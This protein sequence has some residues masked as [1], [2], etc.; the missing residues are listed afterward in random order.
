[1]SAFDTLSPAI[2]GNPGT[3]PRIMSATTDNTLAE[4]TTAGYVA[5][6]VAKKILKTFDILFINYDMDG[7]PGHGVFTVTATSSGSLVSYQQ[8]ASNILANQ[9]SWAG[10]SAS[11][12]FTITG[13]TTSSIVIPAIE[14]QANT[15]YIV[16]YVITANTL[17]ITFSADPGAMVLDYVAF[18]AAQ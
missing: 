18:I 5:D 15:S 9:A 2:Q 10:G 4:I 8:A 17:T 14:T 1:M 11:H 7:T 6:L 16:S 13:L 3:A 12:A